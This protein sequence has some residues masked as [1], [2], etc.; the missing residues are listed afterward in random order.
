MGI[1]HARTG[2]IS[3]LIENLTPEANSKRLGADRFKLLGGEGAD[4]PA[5][6][7]PTLLSAIREGKPYPVKAFLVF[8]NNTLTTYANSSDVYDALTKLEFMVCADLFMTP[9][10]EL[11]D[12]VLPAASWPEINQ[13]V[14]LPTVAANVVLAN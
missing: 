5:A 10:A 9:T 2:S 13:V 6:H 8:G 4:L 7:I 3:K 12:I 14:G 11:A 1:W